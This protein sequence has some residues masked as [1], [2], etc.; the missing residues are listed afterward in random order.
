MDLVLV[1]HRSC[2]IRRSLILK[3][4]SI[5][6]L[7][8]IVLCALISSTLI[9]PVSNAASDTALLTICTSLKGDRQYIFASGKCNEKIYERST[10]YAAGKA[11]SG[12]PGSK[13]VSITLCTSKTSS[14]SQ[15]LSS[16]GRS[17]NRTTQTQSIWQRP[18]GPP[19]APELISVIA[20]TL[21]TAIITNKAPLEDGG[22]RIRS[23]EVFEVGSTTPANKAPL[24]DGGAGIRSYEDIE[25][26]STTPTS[27]ALAT[28]ATSFPI[29]AQQSAKITGL[30]P[31]ESYIFAIRAIN[32]IGASPLSQ[33]SAAFLAPNLPGAPSI[34]SSVASSHNSALITYSPAPS[35]GG[36]SITKYTITSSPG[37]LQSTF[38]ATDAKSHTF[39][40]LSALTTYTFT[41][42]ATNIAGGGLASDL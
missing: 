6:R 24:E 37:R 5:R 3:E 22:A 31:G 38:I 13:K 34:T 18:L 19:V 27:K 11:P 32:A 39:T 26:G 30:I 12:T 28:I 10:W 8:H 2:D 9:T 7:A 21:G 35:D 1:A 17:C 41:I 4:S 23:Y 14:K 15:T 20:N 33:S 25:V 36:S 29:K 40:G 16:K 42:H